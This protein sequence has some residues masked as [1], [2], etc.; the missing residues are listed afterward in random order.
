MLS[1]FFEVEGIRLQ[2]LLLCCTRKLVQNKQIDPHRCMTIDEYMS[3]Q[4]VYYTHYKKGGFICF[5]EI[6]I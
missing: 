3:L 1:L 5:A 2:N 4:I 6:V